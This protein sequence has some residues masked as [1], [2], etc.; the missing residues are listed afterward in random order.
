MYLWPLRHVVPLLGKIVGGDA[1]THS[2]ILESLERYPRPAE[3]AR[4]MEVAGWTSVRWWN[5]LGGVMTIH[6]GIRKS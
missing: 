2:Y 6:R 1:E 5:L 4:R 3:I